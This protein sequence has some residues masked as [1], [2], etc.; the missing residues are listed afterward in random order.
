M[1][2]N[3]ILLAILLLLSLIFGV[4]AVPNYEQE[5]VN[6]LF[7]LISIVF[8]GGASVSLAFNINYTKNVLTNEIRIVNNSPDKSENFQKQSANQIINNYYGGSFYPE[9]G[10]FSKMPNKANQ[11][12]GT[13]LELF[14]SFTDNFKNMCEEWEKNNLEKIVEKVRTKMEKEHSENLTRGEFLKKFLEEG[15]NISDEK[16]Q[17]LWSDI[18]IYELNNKNGIHLRTLEILKNIT[19]D[20]AE[21]FKYISPFVFVD[22]YFYDCFKDNGPSLFQITRMA[23]IGIFKQAYTL[24]WS[25][26]VNPN[27]VEYLGNEEYAII[28]ENKTNSNVELN[29]PVYVLT[30]AGSQLYQSLKC[31][32]SFN[33]IQSITKYVKRKAPK[34]K[35]S[36]RRIANI[37]DGKPIFE[38][39]EVELD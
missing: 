26:T 32:V 10:D 1:N 12:N 7:E 17:E 16:I 35:V 15:K 24:A 34:Q 2:K 5:W 9:D 30:E 19:S 8:A 27:S 13:A 21:L 22:L 23:D 25:P 11:D 33:N 39:K 36:L 6:R 3:T 31:A 28:I 18:F 38:E 4:L 37:V 20:E 29:L 14:N